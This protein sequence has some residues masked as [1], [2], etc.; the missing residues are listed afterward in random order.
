LVLSNLTVYTLRIMLY[1]SNKLKDAKKLTDLSLFQNS[2]GIIFKNTSLLEQALVH[3]SYLNENTG[4]ITASNER[5]EFLGD[6]VLGL[7]IAQKLYQDFPLSSEGQLTQFRAALVRRETLA[8]I[9]AEIK[10]GDCLLLGR[11]EESGGGREKTANLAG[12]FEALIASIYLDQDLDV[13]RTLIIKL[14]GPEIHKQA[15]EVAGTDYKSQ[16]Q[17]IMQAQQQHAPTYHLIEAIG[18]DHA[19]QFTIEV[20]FGATVM[21]RGSGKSKKIAEME[22]ARVAIEN[23]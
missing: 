17:E 13:T 21:G 19:R 11:G 5:L 1:H 18:P 12:A 15:R 10:L 23:L 8:R 3:S 14:F 6:A 7:V 22:A 16:L 4:T 9:A 20:K 2:L